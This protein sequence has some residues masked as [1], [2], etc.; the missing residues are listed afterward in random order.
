MN[1]FW[2]EQSYERLKE[3]QDYISD[4]DSSL[5]AN[6]LIEKL[7]ERGNSLSKFHNRGRIVPELGLEDLRELLEQ[8]YRIVYRVK[9]NK[10]QILSVFEAHRLLQE[11][12]V[13]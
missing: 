10:I 7:I 4:K 1:V 3:I 9:E 11:Q 6:R 13:H 8:N 12:D 2:T 5:K